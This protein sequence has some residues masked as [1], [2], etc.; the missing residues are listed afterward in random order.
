MLIFA[1]ILHF[2]SFYAR[3]LYTIDYFSGRVLS[4][5][6]EYVKLGFGKMRQAIVFS[7]VKLLVL[8]GAANVFFKL[9]I[10][11]NLFNVATA[12]WIP[13][14]LLENKPIISSLKESTVIG[15]RYLP[16]T[17]FLRTGIDITIIFLSLLLIAIGLVPIFILIR[18]VPVEYLNIHLF[19]LIVFLAFFPLISLTLYYDSFLSVVQE[20]SFLFIYL[21]SKGYPLSMEEIVR[22]FKRHQ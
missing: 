16:Q 2:L 11:R 4:S 15:L 13:I 18:S 5:T 14:I 7:I 17:E 3:I 9:K 21:H 19:F 20:S 22:I 8:F 10:P 12:L 6:S 1:C